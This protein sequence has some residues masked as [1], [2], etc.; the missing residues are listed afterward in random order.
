VFVEEGPVERHG[1]RGSG[2]TVYFTDP[3]GTLLEFISYS[4]P[5]RA[6]SWRST[7]LLTRSYEL[8]SCD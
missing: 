1:A 3:D 6:L 7:P 2:R 4:A 8:A 5:L